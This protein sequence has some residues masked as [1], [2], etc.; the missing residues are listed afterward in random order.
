MF[1]TV[2]IAKLK[3][4]NRDKFIEVV[5]KYDDHAIPGYRGTEM[6][7]PENRDD[8]VV[9]CVWFEDADSYW[10]NAKDPAQHERYL[11]YRSLLDSDVE[12]HDGEWVHGPWR[13]M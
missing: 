8:E 3:V 12:W 1:G 2:G 4:E 7:F 6:M 11:E 13:R 9:I 10:N 5:G